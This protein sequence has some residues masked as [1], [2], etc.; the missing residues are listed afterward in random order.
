MLI[1]AVHA[2]AKMVLC[3]TIEKA[4]VHVRRGG[5]VQCVTRHVIAAHMVLHVTRA[6]TAVVGSVTQLQGHACARLEE[7]ETLVKK[8]VHKEAM[9]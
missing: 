8:N 9:V 6:V 2:Y 3:V 7:Q 1:V 4:A 5:M